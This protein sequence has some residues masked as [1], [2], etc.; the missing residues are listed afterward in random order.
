[1]IGAFI[2]WT[3]VALLFAVIGQRAGKSEKPVG[4]F[5]G[6]PAVKMKDVKE[7]N[8]AVARI[9]IRF[10]VCLEI[11]GIP[12]IFIEQNSLISIFLVFGVV[13]LVFGIILSYF[14]VEAK[15]RE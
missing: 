14:K 3:A 4:F 7:Y 6:V 15:Y 12:L 8:R 13:I 9:W 5:T 1:M 2:G 11:L 10:A